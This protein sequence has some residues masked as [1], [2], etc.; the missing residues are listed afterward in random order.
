MDNFAE[1]TF[2]NRA[3]RDERWEALMLVKPHVVR[4]TTT[5]F[6]HVDEDLRTVGKMSWR[7]RYPILVLP[8]TSSTRNAWN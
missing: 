3:A 4:D 1:E 6:S 8:S 2:S 7:V 5:V